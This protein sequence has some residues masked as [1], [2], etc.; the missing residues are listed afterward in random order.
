[1]QQIN[2]QIGSDLRAHDAQ[3][4]S[5][6]IL[7]GRFDHAVEHWIFRMPD[8]KLPRTMI[9]SIDHM[10]AAPTVDEAILIYCTQGQGWVYD[11][12][13]IIPVHTGDLILC[14]VGSDHGYGTDAAQ[15]WSIDWLHFDGA[16]AERMANELAYT[17]TCIQYSA[18]PETGSMLQRILTLLQGHPNQLQYSAANTYL[19]T[20]LYEI[21]LY[22]DQLTAPAQ[23]QTALIENAIDYMESHLHEQCTLDQVSYHVGMSKYHFSRLFKAE[24]D[25]APMAFFNRMKMQAACHLLIQGNRNVQEVSRMLGYASPYYFSDLFKRHIGIPPKRYQIKYR[26]HFSSEIISDPSSSASKE[27]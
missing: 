17:G 20:M 14:D 18:P 15:P 16:L 3:S 27:T 9:S 24:K 11:T 22:H 26:Q 12:Q 5:S 7:A 19:Q 23:K 10:K 25:Y 1:M 13:R 21:V 2:I 4:L 6:I 8:N